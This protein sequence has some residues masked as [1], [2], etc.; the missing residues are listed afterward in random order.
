MSSAD[1]A[2]VGNWAPAYFFVT[3]DDTPR[4]MIMADTF[5]DEGMTELARRLEVPIKGD[6]T[7]QVN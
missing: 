5:S 4:I 7:A 3:Q 6:F 2:Y 1:R